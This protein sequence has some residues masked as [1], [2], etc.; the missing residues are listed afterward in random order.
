MS[1]YL[2]FK[3][4]F[5]LVGLL[6]LVGVGF[7]SCKKNDVPFPENNSVLF[8]L[9][10]KLI[11][12]STLTVEADSLIADFS[13]VSDE[14]G[15]RWV[16]IAFSKININTNVKVRFMIRSG[17]LELLQQSGP[18]PDMWIK[19]SAY[20]DSEHPA[21]IAKA[22]H[23]TNGIEGDYNRA[24]NIQLFVADFINYHVFKDCGLV[25]ASTTLQNGYG[26]CINYSRLFVALCRSVGIPAR[27]VSGAMYPG[28]NYNFQHTWAEFLDDDGQWHPVDMS[29]TKLIDIN[30]LR[31][32]DLLYAAEQNRYY[33]DYVAFR[34]S[35]N[36][37]Y[38][39][40]DGSENAVDGKLKIDIITNNFPEEM[41][42]S[43]SYEIAKLFID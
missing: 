23:L 10:Q 30:D 4:N 7:A 1:N 19:Q 37:D 2:P 25:S 38:Y 40:Y 9:P 24:R 8:P 34:I 13:I 18:I 6:L 27:S 21:I 32:L 28:G 16:K 15:G 35:E 17:P 26:T 20:I 39:F 33:Q 31:Y 11:I 22:K 43:M 36:G 41:E 3:L 14:Y 42:L 5:Q 12:D 29:Y